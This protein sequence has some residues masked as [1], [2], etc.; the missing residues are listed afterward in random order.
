MAPKLFVTG[1][2]GYIGGSATD[3]IINAHPDYEIAALVRSDDKAE[4]V[5][6]KY[7]SVRVVKGDL[8]SA[9]I[10]KAE[11][12]KADIVLHFADC[13][14]V[15]SAKAITEGLAAC[16]GP[17]YFIHTSGSAMLADVSK[18]ERFGAAIL[19]DEHYADISTLSAIT[20]FPVEGHVHRDVDFIVLSSPSNVHTAIV[21]PP[22]IYGAGSGPVNTRSIQI[23]GLTSAILKR[24]KGF[25]VRGGKNGWNYVHIRD[26]SVLYLLLTEAAARGGQGADWNEEGYYFSENGEYLWGELARDITKRA[27]AKGY[28]KSDEV[29]ELEP[30]EVKK[31]HP[32]GHVLW[33]SN[34]K[35]KAERARKKLGWTPTGESLVETLDEVIEQE[36]KRLQL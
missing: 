15:A 35:G 22:T 12:A 32:F 27:A 2:T 6:A 26:L 8:D 11:C 3:A 31:L 16:D 5:K 25:T 20:S 21:C 30:E 19:E 29:D 28:I 34:S 33:G 18:P 17:K 14:H 4:L 10:I 1:I 36:A 7:P 24:G 13:D 23:P 9:D